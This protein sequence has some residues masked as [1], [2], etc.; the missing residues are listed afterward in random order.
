VAVLPPV[1]HAQNR[2]VDIAF[3]ALKD[4]AVADTRNAALTFAALGGL[5]GAGLGSAGGL[6]RKDGRAAATAALLGL[7]VGAAASAGIA[8]LLLPPYYAFQMRTPDEALH[9]LFLPLLVHTGLWAPAGAVGGWAF[10]RG[11]AAR[12]GA[13]A[14]VLGGFFG[15]IVGT[16]LYEFLGA[17]AFPLAA[18][19]HVI[20]DTIATRLLARV[21]V[22]TCAA[23]GVAFG[24]T[25]KLSPGGE[26]PSAP[27]R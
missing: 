6:S 3:I 27:A 15:V 18:S 23:A 1:S 24:L 25:L 20:S 4:L 5:L 26:A 2:G 14:L 10:A 7:V 8:M 13:L 19:H 11:L 17:L 21:V 22:T 12:G 9:D 16:I